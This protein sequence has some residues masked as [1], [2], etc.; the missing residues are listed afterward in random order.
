MLKSQTTL[1]LGAG[2]SA[3]YGFPIGSSLRDLLL[4]LDTGVEAL[5]GAVR[6]DVDEWRSVQRILHDFQPES[7]DDFLRQYAEHADLTKLAIAYHL[8]KFE[9]A[10]AHVNVSNPDP[11]YRVLLDE[12]LDNDVKLGDGKL[13]IVTF[14]YDLSLE[15]YLVRIREATHPC[16][17]RSATRRIFVMPIIRSAVQRTRLR[18]R[19]SII[20]LVGE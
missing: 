2:A 5:I 8:S 17:S 12:F 16:R 13:S 6:T 9:N 18:F 10:Q 20:G 7:V 11:W 3:P 19:T 1:I 4:K 14:N 15:A